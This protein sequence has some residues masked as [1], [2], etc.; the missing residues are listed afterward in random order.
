MFSYYGSKSKIINYYPVP[1][2]PIIIEPFC[3]SA[4]YS[5][6][7]YEKE[8]WLNDSYKVIS[9]V[10]EWIINATS[11]QINKI[12]I[13][14]RGDDLRL[15]E[16]IDEKLRL[17]MGFIVNSGV[18]KPRNIVTQWR[19]EK[20]EFKRHIKKLQNYCG[21]LKHWKVT[22]IDYNNLPD[23]EATWYIDPPY[24]EINVSKKQAYVH[25]K[26]NYNELAEWCKSRKGQ[27]IVCENSYAKWLPF[28]PLK[29]MHGQRHK[30]TEVIWT[31]D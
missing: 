29:E 3:G 1:K 25:N 7:Y 28:I 9:D 10:W 8:C 14:K 15:V 22:N 5:L 16:G 20:Q 12:P 24:Q 27:V 18:E 2:F 4:R 19:E 23:I 21:K 13:L 26:I 17:L 11:S 6:K 31:N 30:T